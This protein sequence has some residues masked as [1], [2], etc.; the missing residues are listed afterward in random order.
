MTNIV[1]LVKDR[2]LLT[3][4]AIDSLYENTPREDFN[5]TVV[6]NGSYDFRVVNL[7]L[8]L[9][10][11]SNFTGIRIYNTNNV[12]S[13]AKNLGVRWSAFRFKPDIRDFL[14]VVDNDVFFLP[15]W[16]HTMQE[17]YGDTKSLAIMG[18]QR[19]PFHQINK[20]TDTGVDLT[21]AVAGYCH[22]MTWNEWNLVGPYDHNTA[23]GT[24]QSEDSDICRRAYTQGMEIGYCR[25]PT[26]LH[27]GI[28]TSDGT[29]A[30]GADRFERMPGVLY[31]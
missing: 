1:M 28:T 18:G 25:K 7:I 3:K 27:C 12:L 6:E 11:R 14:C 13:H 5:L 9:Q 16:L 30:L 31:A 22:F 26:V 17:A 21:D 8:S 15:G 19:H 4:Q 29:P 20:A 24:G 10:S 2:Y 23:P